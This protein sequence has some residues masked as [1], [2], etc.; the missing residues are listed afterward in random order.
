MFNKIGVSNVR[1]SYLA[2]NELYLAIGDTITA[3]SWFSKYVILKDS[4]FNEESDKR[5]SNLELV[6]DAEKKEKEIEVLNVENKLKDLQIEVT[7]KWIIVLGTGL[8]LIIIFSLITLKQKAKLR[9]ANDFLVHKNLEII[10]SDKRLIGFED[11]LEN[12]DK[13]VANKKEGPS[14]NKYTHSPLLDKQKE[15]LLVRIKNRFR[16]GKGLL[17]G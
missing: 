4:L 14:Q 13:L 3:Y 8:F 17:T 9:R 16:R 1:D 11:N 15:K 6:Y 12:M 2:F 10:N 7:K 5:I